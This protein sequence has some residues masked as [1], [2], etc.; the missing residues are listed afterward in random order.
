[1][2]TQVRISVSEVEKLNSISKEDKKSLFERF[3]D[4]ISIELYG[5]KSFNWGILK[6][7]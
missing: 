6:G 5:E 3:Y 4:L 7:L 1:M 2:K